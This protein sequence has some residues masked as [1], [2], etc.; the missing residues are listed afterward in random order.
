MKFLTVEIETP[1]TKT[2]A[3]RITNPP[4][5]VSILRAVDGMPEA[6]IDRLKN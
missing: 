2:V 3:E 6:A 4:V 1:I 5:I